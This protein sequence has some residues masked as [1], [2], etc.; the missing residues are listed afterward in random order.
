MYKWEQI[1][2]QGRDLAQRLLS[3]V[4]TTRCELFTETSFNGNFVTS[5]TYWNASGSH[6]LQSVEVPTRDH[7]LFQSR[8]C[9]RG[10]TNHAS[11]DVGLVSSILPQSPACMMECRVVR[12]R[13]QLPTKKGQK[14]LYTSTTSGSTL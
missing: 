10:N 1:L 8:P 3:Q 7:C 6:H 5:E 11:S 14:I 12:L 13:W 2:L 4:T 9:I